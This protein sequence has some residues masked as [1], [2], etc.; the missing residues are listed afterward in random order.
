MKTRLA[1]A[2]SVIALTL[3][4]ASTSGSANEDPPSGTNADSSE[5][6]AAEEPSEEPTEEDSGVIAFGE[7]Y[8]YEDGLTVTLSPPAPFKPSYKE[9]VTG[10]GQPIQF[11][12]TIVNNTGAPFDPSGVYTT[13]QSGNE[14]GEELFDTE[15]G[16]DGSPTTTLL[17]GRESKF[18]IG[19]A[20]KDPADLV[21]QMT[22]SYDYEDVIYTS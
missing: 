7:S 19:Y 16:L 20:V 17:D 21:L 12:V 1:A 8:T 11:E 2:L 4:C 14:E 18:K 22:P 13:V 9:V 15:A 10:D 5:A 3:G 6:A